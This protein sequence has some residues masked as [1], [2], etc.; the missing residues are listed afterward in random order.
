MLDIY[1]HSNTSFIIFFETTALKT[2]LGMLIISNWEQKGD[3]IYIYC[4]Q[5]NVFM[6]K[7]HF[8]GIGRH[9]IQPTWRPQSITGLLCTTLDGLIIFPDHENIGIDTNLCQI[10]IENNGFMDISSRSG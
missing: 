9:M 8:C 1:T 10:L 2:E 3:F 4:F 5:G 7:Y 6:G